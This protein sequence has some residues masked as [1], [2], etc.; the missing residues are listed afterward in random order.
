MRAYKYHG[1]GHFVNEL[2]TLNN[3]R[4]FLASH[5]QIYPKDIDLKVEHQGKYTTFLELI[6]KLLIG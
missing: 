2:L 5:H 6:L 1:T 3:F 4:D